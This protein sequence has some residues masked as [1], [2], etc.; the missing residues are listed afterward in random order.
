VI[1]VADERLGEVGLAFVVPAPGMSPTTTEIVAWARERKANYKVPRR[2]EIVTSLP[3]NATGKV[4][5]DELRAAAQGL[6]H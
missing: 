5:K 2:I 4:L 3:L 1:G 6:G